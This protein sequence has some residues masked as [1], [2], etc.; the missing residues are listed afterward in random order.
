M[1]GGWMGSDRIKVAHLQE[2]T[3]LRTVTPTNGCEGSLM[4]RFW[5]IA[6][7]VAGGIA[8]ADYLLTKVRDVCGSAVDAADALTDAAKKIRDKFRGQR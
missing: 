7:S 4:S 5:E 2:P 8:A 1:N 3:G 6:I